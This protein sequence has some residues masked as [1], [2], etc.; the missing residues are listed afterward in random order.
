MWVSR[1][2]DWVVDRLNY[3]LDQGSIPIEGE[4]LDRGKVPYWCET[5]GRTILFLSLNQYDTPQ[6]GGCESPHR[7]VDYLNYT[8]DRDIPDQG[9]VARLGKSAFYCQFIYSIYPKFKKKSI[10][11]CFY[12]LMFFFICAVILLIFQE[13]YSLIGKAYVLLSFYIQK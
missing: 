3:T 5:I 11:F 1:A 8:L 6:I 12:F 4:S 2:P 7:V 10:F 9:G 13:A